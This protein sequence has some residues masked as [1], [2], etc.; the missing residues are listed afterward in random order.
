[1][2]KIRDAYKSTKN[3]TRKSFKNGFQHIRIYIHNKDFPQ[4][5]F[6]FDF[7]IDFLRSNHNLRLILFMY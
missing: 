2:R 3:L 7:H 4:N 6:I 5:F 1:M